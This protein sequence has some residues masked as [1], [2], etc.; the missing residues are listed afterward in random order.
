MN[1]LD[2]KPD[3]S[4]VFLVSAPDGYRSL[5]SYGEVFLDP[6]GGRV[7]LADRSNGKPLKRG[8]KFFLAPPDDLMADRD[9]KAVEKIE[10]IS[11]R[12]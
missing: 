7:I 10:L 2:V 6:A 5:F 3:L 12:K 1:T 8:G 4:Q 11:L 9:V